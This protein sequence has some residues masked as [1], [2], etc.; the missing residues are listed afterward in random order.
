M[1][2]ET[3]NSIN[4]F[5]ILGLA[6]IT[7][8]HQFVPNIYFISLVSEGQCEFRTSLEIVPLEV[9]NPITRKN[10]PVAGPVTWTIRIQ[11]LS[12]HPISLVLFE[13]YLLNG[14]DRRIPYSNMRERFS[15]YDPAL[16]T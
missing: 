16:Q 14:N 4:A 15:P 9:L 12:D 7:A 13:G 1:T 11:S 2:H 6:A 3:F 5:L 10:Q 8:R